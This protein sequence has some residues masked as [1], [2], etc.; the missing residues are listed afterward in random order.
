M[1]TKNKDIWFICFIYPLPLHWGW[2]CP[3]PKATDSVPLSGV[4]RGAWV[5]SR[6]NFRFITASEHLTSDLCRTQYFC[7]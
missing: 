6:V 1:V 7:R 4:L 2:Q 5:D 3:V